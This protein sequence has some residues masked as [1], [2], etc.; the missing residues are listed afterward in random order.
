M[1]AILAFI[2]VRLILQFLHEDVWHAIPTIPTPASLAVILTVLLV[3][4]PRRTWRLTYVYPKQEE[5]SEPSVGANSGRMTVQ[6][7]LRGDG[8]PSLPPQRFPMRRL[9]GTR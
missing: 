5:A 9:T 3:R 2:G 7:G 1:A 8:L 6:S 4:R